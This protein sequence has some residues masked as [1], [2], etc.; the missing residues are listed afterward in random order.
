ML[1]GISREDAIKMLLNEEEKDKVYYK[2]DGTYLKVINNP[3]SFHSR[4]NWGTSKTF[5]QQKFYMEICGEWE[6]D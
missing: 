5:T 6:N 3:W 1:I 2:S 4:F